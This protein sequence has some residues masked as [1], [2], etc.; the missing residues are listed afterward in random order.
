MTGLAYHLQDTDG[1]LDDP[2]S[3]TSG[4]A[5][6][7]DAGAS[8]YQPWQA[9]GVV[10]GYFESP[11][12]S[13]NEGERCAATLAATCRDG[14]ALNDQHLRKL[15]LKFTLPDSLDVPLNEPE[16]WQ[17]KDSL[18]GMFQ[19]G[20]PLLKALVVRATVPEE[21]L[22]WDTP[23][24][25]TAEQEDQWTLLQEQRWWVA[26]VVCSL[27]VAAPWG[28]LA[29]GWASSAYPAADPNDPTCL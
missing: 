10:W 24:W 3:G 4:S 9:T 20:Q 13:S 28:V 6:G 21:A 22:P 29:C 15:W 5:T 27:P 17:V 7:A 14:L 18:T 19:R 1:H 26:P 25:L 16:P 11:Q 23:Y 2:A 12:S 8:P